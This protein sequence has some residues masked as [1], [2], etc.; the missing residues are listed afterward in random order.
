MNI[1]WIWIKITINYMLD[2]E[3]SLFL[4]YFSE[5]KISPMIFSE[6]SSGDLWSYI[7]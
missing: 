7:K 6:G 3:M 5:D 4:L 1:Q 2:T